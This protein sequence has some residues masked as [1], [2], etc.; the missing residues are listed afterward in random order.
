VAVEVRDCNTTHT[1]GTE[2]AAAAGCSCSTVPSVAPILTTVAALVENAS[3]DTSHADGPGAADNIVGCG[4]VRPPPL[5]KSQG[6]L[7]R[8]ARVAPLSSTSAHA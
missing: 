2:A 5:P 4:S 8:S 3:C 1:D 6:F 7:R